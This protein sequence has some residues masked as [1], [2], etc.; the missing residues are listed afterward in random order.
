[1]RSFGVF[2]YLNLLD[3]LSTMIVLGHG[4]AEAN[5]VTR[6]FIT[7]DHRIYIGLVAEK[8][9]M[10]VTSW[11]LLKLVVRRFGLNRNVILITW[12]SA[13]MILIVWNLCN[14]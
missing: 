4:G 1:M 12:N 5:P 8:L 3:V 6:W 11:Y 9:I 2:L 13:Y 7:L 14:I 10:F